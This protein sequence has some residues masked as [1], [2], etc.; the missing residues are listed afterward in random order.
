MFLH[1]EK[2]REGFQKKERY[3]PGAHYPMLKK[4]HQN[5]KMWGKTNLKTLSVPI[6]RLFHAE[7]GEFI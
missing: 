4:V 2:A 3:P 7:Q 1:G 5:I 6:K